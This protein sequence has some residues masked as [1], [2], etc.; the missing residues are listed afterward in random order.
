MSI[1]RELLED[2]KNSLA[3]R[4]EAIELCEL[5]IDHFNLDIW[6]V[7]DAFGDELLIELYSR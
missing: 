3:D 6:A 5:I 7:M 4:Y 1:D 2:Y